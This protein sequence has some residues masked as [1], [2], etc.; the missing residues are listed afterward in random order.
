MRASFSALGA[1][2]LFGFV[3][4]SL[5]LGC[6][7]A[8]WKGAG[9]DST[10]QG[11]GASDGAGA[12]Y[13]A[14][15]SDP[16]GGAGASYSEGGDSNG[17]PGGPPKATCDDPGAPLDPSILPE[18]PGACGGR[19]VPKAL[20]PNPEDPAV[21]NLGE[22]EPGSGDLCVPDEFV[23]TKGLYV[24]PSCD[25]YGLEGRCMSECVP[26]IAE[27]VSQGILSQGTC[28]EHHVCTPCFDPTTGKST[29]ACT[30]EC[31][32]G[33]DPSKDHEFPSCCGGIGTCVPKPLAGAQGDK[34]GQDACPAGGNLVC[35]PN[36]LMP[37]SGYVGEDCT[38]E[39][40]F[41]E[42][43]D[44]E[45]A[46]GKCLPDCIP[47]LDSI[48]LNDTGQCGPQHKCAPC[49]QPSVVFDQETNAPG[50]QY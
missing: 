43:V 28:A 23:A 29:G 1:T 21:A 8:S 30:M 3:V 20:L 5:G 33:P 31:D 50:C 14:G 35:A 25:F 16:G 12:T 42:L 45:H 48:F 34:L 22:C 24:P 2:G 4:V 18:C 36:E 49:W 41:L 46:Y 7:T 11:E 6:A 19:C 47:S 17:D 27:Q 44:P 39:F 37:N 9:K 38:P 40:N 13:G 32:P 26:Q 10:A 15:A